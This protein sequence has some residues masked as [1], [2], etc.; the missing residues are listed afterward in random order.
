MSWL[1]L[2]LAVF[3][4]V[5]KRVTVLYIISPDIPIYFRSSGKKPSNLVLIIRKVVNFYP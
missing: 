5:I 1:H 4:N 2:Y 3:P